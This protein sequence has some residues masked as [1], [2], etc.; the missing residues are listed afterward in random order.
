LC[1]TAAANHGADGKS[2]HVFVRPAKIAAV[3]GDQGLGGR[4]TRRDVKPAVLEDDAARHAA[5]LQFGDVVT[6]DGV[7]KG[8]AADR[9]VDVIGAVG[10]DLSRPDQ[11]AAKRDGRSVDDG[12][13]RNGQGPTAEHCRVEQLQH[14]ARDQGDPAQRRA[15]ADV[16]AVA[17]HQLVNHRAAAVDRDVA[18]QA[19]GGDQGRAAGVDDEAAG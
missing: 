15:V 4:R 7:A 1:S 12:P 8:H 11:L 19:A 14:A 18:G 9:T 16:L 13:G 3:I 6:A 10:A 5:G 2:G 17:D